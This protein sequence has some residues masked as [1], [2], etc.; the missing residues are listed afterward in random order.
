LYLLPCI[1]EFRDNLRTQK[2]KD[3][4]TRGIQKQFVT[5]CLQ[6]D[7]QHLAPGYTQS[8]LADVLGIHQTLVSLRQK[9]LRSKEP[10]SPVGKPHKR[11][12]RKDAFEIEHE[13]VVETI[14]DFWVHF[15]FCS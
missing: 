10:I 2:A 3:D 4:K 15:S 13:D 6:N 7:N 12:K 11:A 9:R 14:E 8:Q 1:N 5:L